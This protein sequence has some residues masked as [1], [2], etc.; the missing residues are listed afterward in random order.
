MS[1]EIDALGAL[2]TAGLAADAL[3][4]PGAR[5]A[6]IDA[7]ATADAGHRCANCAAPLHG[8][9]CA[10]CGQ[11][12][13][14]H[15]SL[16]HVGEEILHGITHFDGKTWKTLP[17]LVFKPG[18]LTR[19]Y[20]QGKRARYV[21]PVPLFLLVVFLMFFV[22]SFVNIGD[23]IGGDDATA[24]NGKPLSV[25]EAKVELPKV[26]AELAKLDAEIAAAKAN[27]G[28]GELEALQGVR[29]GV[30]A[31]RDKVQARAKGE[32]DTP[33]DIPGE[34]SREIKINGVTADFGS[35]S[36][37]AKARA[38]MKNPELVFYKIQGKAYKFSF[39]LVPLSLPWLW[40]L[41][42]TRREVKMYDHAIFSL[43]LISFMSLLFI[44][45]SG[46]L[47]LGIT[48]GWLWLPLLNA[49]V[50]HMY[51]Q[52]KGAYALTRGAAVWRTAVLALA[53]W[54]TLSIYVV[55]MILMG[56]LG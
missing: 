48:S 24:V 18:T 3:N 25:A 38:A 55:L 30:M 50:V 26:E 37:N 44:I 15:R 2:A 39:L 11:K 34:I 17:M 41:F 42:A 13:H 53:S 29:I 12:A 9:F 16:V 46:A 35:E 10:A 14:V 27:P 23:N 22:F 6:D 52:L 47:S 8:E 36:L 33:T 31:A 45:A 43:Y 1:D 32:I 4:R 7:A 54:L 49:P 19:D 20:I 5:S 56:V 21:A 28:Y 51:A 40:L